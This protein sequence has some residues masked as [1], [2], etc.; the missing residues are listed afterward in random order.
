MRKLFQLIRHIRDT[1]DPPARKLKGV[2]AQQQ[3]LKE[4]AEEAGQL[5]HSEEGGEEEEDF[6]DDICVDPPKLATSS[7]RGNGKASKT[8]KAKGSKDSEGKRDTAMVSETEAPKK[9]TNAIED[10]EYVTPC[11]RFTKKGSTDFDEVVI[12]DVTQSKEKQ[13]LD[14]L[15]RKISNLKLKLQTQGL[16][17]TT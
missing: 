2:C 1:S 6:E 11:R 3:K 8:S 15:V 4:Q 13:Q 7:N 10:P 16:T 17:T 14:D 5:E 12:T 9:G